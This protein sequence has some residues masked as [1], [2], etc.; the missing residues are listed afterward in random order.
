[1]F[2]YLIHHVH[3]Y[4]PRKRRSW[5]DGPEQ[6]A[7]QS[8][9]YD[10]AVERHGGKENMPMVSP[11]A[12]EIEFLIL[13]HFTPQPKL[14]FGKVKVCSFYLTTGFALFFTLNHVTK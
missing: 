1:M 9:T 4:S 2:C 7:N 12:E 11:P 13:D 10:I 14:D 6:I 3:T 8:L 5:N